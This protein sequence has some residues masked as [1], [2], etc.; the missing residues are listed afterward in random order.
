M[1][2]ANLFYCEVKQIYQ[3]SLLRKSYFLA[4]EE[5]LFQN[6]FNDSSTEYI[7]NKLKQKVTSLF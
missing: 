3:N 2:P 7:N 6:D 5:N 4:S 1:W